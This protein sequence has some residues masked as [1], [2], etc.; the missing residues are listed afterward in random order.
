M[1][2]GLKVMAHSLYCMPRNR[3]PGTMGVAPYSV[4]A[5]PGGGGASS[6][7]VLLPRPLLEEMSNI[8]LVFVSPVS[9]WC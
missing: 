2:M 5:E 6:L 8:Y 7:A 4:R 3:K 9:L 1:S